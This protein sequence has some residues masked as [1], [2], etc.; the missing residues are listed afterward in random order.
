MKTIRLLL[1]SI[2]IGIC[3]SCVDKIDAV[4]N[5]ETLSVADGIEEYELFTVSS[6]SIEMCFV[7][8]VF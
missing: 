1:I 5:E 6:G 8:Y 3:V 7:P 2:V 4:N